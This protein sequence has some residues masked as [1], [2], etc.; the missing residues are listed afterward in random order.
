MTRKPN[1]L[2][3]S[4][5]VP[6][7]GGMAFQAQLMHDRL[8]AEGIRTAFLPSN[9]PFPNSVRFLERIR[10]ARPF[11]RLP[12]FCWSLWRL[13][14]QSDVVHILACSWLYF[15]VIVCPSVLLSRLR[16]KKIVMNYR[17]GEGD[18]FFRQYGFL[19]KPFFRMADVI[20]APSQF[21]VDVIDKHF[22]LPVQVVPNIVDLSL[23]AHRARTPLQPHMIV[24]RHL[25]KLYDVE[26]VIRA[27]GEVQ[28]QYPEASLRVV[29]TGDQEKYL[30]DLVANLGL[31]NVEFFG[32]VAHEKLPALYDQCGFLLNA[33]LA[34]N[35]PGSLVEGA[36][37]GL[38]VVSTA[39]GGIPYIFEDGKTALLVKPKDWAGMASAILRAMRDPALAARVT[40]EAFRQ[41]K[42]YEWASVSR[43]L[44]AHYGMDIAGE[45]TAGLS[46]AAREA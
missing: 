34:D 39:V 11:L 30:R 23:F 7:Y 12:F 17:G 8:N 5:K 22:G 28:K 1:I 24:T 14:G 20:T 3:I 40:E 25:I 46:V 36:A 15:F 9:F 42:R 45:T 21:L 19:V 29:G 2:L 43:L 26:T 32:F 10:G 27:F 44:Y 16:G 37:S 31:R 13:L 33:S 4:P 41:C 35:F 38:L 18:D 6:P